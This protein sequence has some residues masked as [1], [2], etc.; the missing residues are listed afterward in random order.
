MTRRVLV[1]DLNDVGKSDKFDVIVCDPPFRYARTVGSG[2]ADNHYATMDLADL[3]KLNVSAIAKPNCALLMWA[4]GPT[5]QNAIE[6]MGDWGFKYSTV[7]I[8]WVKTSKRSERTKPD[9]RNVVRMGLGSW[10]FPSSEFVLAGTRGQ[11]LK[12][13]RRQRI[14]Q[15]LVAPR[16]DHSQKPLEVWPL[17]YSF[18]NDGVRIV[19]LFARV[20]A[21]GVSRCDKTHSVW[22]LEASERA[23]VMRTA[24]RAPRGGAD[25]KRKLCRL[26]DDPCDDGPECIRCGVRKTAQSFHKNTRRACGHVATCKDCCRSQYLQQKAANEHRAQN[27]ETRTCSKCNVTKPFDAFFPA[28]TKCKRCFIDSRPH[29]TL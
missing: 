28:K 11:P 2:V 16:R 29:N 9:F 8:N 26:Q 24:D 21:D 23:P 3:K 12:H 25:K 17:I 10:S 13:H 18:F 14:S 6:L 19:E 27:S 20:T 1:G 4:S 22:G 15:L 5:M 7:F